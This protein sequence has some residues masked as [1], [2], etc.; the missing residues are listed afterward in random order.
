M[1][2]QKKMAFR[3]TLS[4]ATALAWGVSSWN[5]WAMA[6]VS[7]WD[8]ATQPGPNGSVRY[9]GPFLGFELG[10][11]LTPPWHYFRRPPAESAAASEP[12]A[13]AVAA[14]RAAERYYYDLDRMHRYQLREDRYAADYRDRY[15]SGDPLYHAYRGVRPTQPTDPTTPPPSLHRLPPAV[16]PDGA[17]P[18]VSLPSG[19]QARSFHPDEAIPSLLRGACN[20]LLD[21]LS[22]MRDG[23]LWRDQLQP[24]RII[25]SIDHA[26]YPAA[27]IDLVEVYEA[28]AHNPRL[29]LVA[30]A[31][32]FA[33]VHQLLLQYVQLESRYP[34]A[35][36]VPGT[37]VYEGSTVYESGTV[38]GETISPGYETGPGSDRS[39][40][41]LGETI[42]TP[43]PSVDSAPPS[44]SVP[45]PLP[46]DW[47]P[48]PYPETRS[49]TRSET[50][51]ETKPAVPVE[52]TDDA[53][54]AGNAPSTGGSSK[55]AG[56]ADGAVILNRPALQPPSLDAVPV[57]T[58]TVAGT[59][60][61]AAPL[62]PESDPTLQ[63]T[64]QDLP[65]IQWL[66][67]PAGTRE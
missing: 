17:V 52:T 26:E 3:L 42:L 2:Q 4:L 48:T 38:Y 59:E 50:R 13:N 36:S 58:P 32:G 27:L 61:S 51:Q 22:R 12:S 16:Y 49:E 11:S 25:A 67:R 47:I 41:P 10:A 18:G 29:V 40:A 33:E 8:G 23:K 63:V 44:L 64:P 19:S 46:D 54:E 65:T 31:N 7:A 15:T 28:V 21:S 30:R 56:G 14:A 34:A 60:P 62:S 43:L 35:I 57:A 39:L 37:A 5:S 24:H 1:L 45:R 9:Q 66:P 6:Q 55:P 53:A 20:R